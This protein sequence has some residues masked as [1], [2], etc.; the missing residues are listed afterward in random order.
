MMRIYSPISLLLLY[1]T[2]SWAELPV[3]FT[4]VPTINNIAIGQQQTLNYVIHNNV[5]RRSL[6]IRSIQIINDGDTQS[7]SVTQSTTTC[8]N[9]LPP[10][11]SCEISV[12]IQNA[13]G[14]INRRLSINYGG[15]SPLTSPIKLKVSKAKY[16]VFVY[17]IGADLQSKHQLATFNID[18]M[19]KV[20]STEN[21][22][23]VLQTGGANSPGYLTV[24]RQ[25]VYPGSLF[26]LA[27]LG[28]VP[29]AAPNTIQDFLEWGIANYPAER[30][31]TIFW[32]HGGGPNGGFGGDENNPPQAIA[33]NNLASVINNVRATTGNLFEIIGFDACLMGSAETAAGF[34]SNMHYFIGSEDLEPGKGWQYD[35][36]LSYLNAYPNASGNEIG[37][38]II[39]GYTQQNEGE[40]TTLSLIDASQLSNLN[41]AMT[42]FAT[43]LSPYTTTTTDWKLIAKSRFKA[44][45]YSTSVWDNRSTDLVDLVEFAQRISNQFPADINLSAASQAVV[46]AVNQAVLYYKNSFDRADSFGLTVYFPSILA[47]YETQYPQVTAIN[48]VNF[49]SQLYVNLV[50][51]YHTFYQNNI[52]S[53]VAI[54]SNL[55]FD[56]T[57]YTATLSNDYN[58]LYAA[59]GNESCTNLLDANNNPLPANP[60]YSSIQYQGIAATQ[61]GTDWN[62]SFPKTPY[63]NSWPLLNGLPV[64][65]IPDDATPSNPGET[66]FLIPVTQIQ[67]GSTTDGYLNV[68]LNQQNQFQVVGFQSGI[69]SSN[70]AAKI[71]P[72][73]PDSSFRIRSYAQVNSVWRL[74]Q[75]TE[76][77]NYPFTVSFGGVSSDLNAFRFLAGDITGALIISPTSVPY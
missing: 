16:S 47:Q 27:D 44:A 28:S 32:N 30:Y 19:K 50:G 52:S 63:L 24:K 67:E 61:A 15:R 13:T 73:S 68:L 69:G 57:N 9:S 55:A 21:I 34:A 29:M 11:G 26:E 75:T 62:I 72:L 39:D 53:L 37:R 31:I 49:F 7:S 70:T 58:E 2:A 65:F 59:V 3:S 45:D 4:S 74:T 66:N 12:T 42:N 71:I 14:N 18:Q 60:C 77:V 38:V 36:F 46:S 40:A 5:V 41:M 22:N 64:L 54:L 8:G 33:I 20:G 48:G 6:P 25:I 1:S 51:N 17:I 10:N 76:T 43:A 56:G 35:T 23:V